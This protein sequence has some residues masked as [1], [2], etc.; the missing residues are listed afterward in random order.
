MPSAF[1]KPLH[2]VPSVNDGDGG[3]GGGGLRVMSG[4]NQVRK[5]HHN[6][7]GRTRGG[8]AW[9]FSFFVL[10]LYSSNN[11]IFQGL[12]LFDT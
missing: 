4:L 2:A 7:L 12:Q 8:K 6:A 3:V 11:F 10:L 5:T 9:L 1:H